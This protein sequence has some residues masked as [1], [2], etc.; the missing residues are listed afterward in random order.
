VADL[1]EQVLLPSVVQGL[2][3]GPLLGLLL[4]ALG[5]LAER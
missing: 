2:V 3:D 5:L 4:G 1:G